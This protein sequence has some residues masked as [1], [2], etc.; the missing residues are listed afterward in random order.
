MRIIDLVTR[1]GIASV[2]PIVHLHRTERNSLF[3]VEKGMC[4]SYEKTDIYTE[5]YNFTLEDLLNAKKEVE[6][7]ELWFLFESLLRLAV[8]LKEQGMN[9]A[10]EL[11]NVFLTPAG[12]PCV[13][14]YHLRSIK[15]S[16]ECSEFTMGQSIAKIMLQLALSLTIEVRTEE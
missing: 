4:V 9:I 7:A 16:I 13:Y 1:E 10:L 12:I 2:I 14:H 6:E 3:S 15:E 11:D 8:A 5:Y